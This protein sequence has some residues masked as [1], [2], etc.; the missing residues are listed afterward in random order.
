MAEY[1]WSIAV[2][3][4]NEAE[5][6]GGCLAAIDAAC[7]AHRGHVTVLLNGTT[8]NSLE[9]INR[10]PLTNVDLAVYTF[11][12]ADKAN[13]INEFFY[14]L[15]RTAEMN[16]FVDAYARVS[17]AAFQAIA[18]EFTAH[19]EALIATGVPVTGRSATQ[20]SIATL[21]GGAVNG[22]LYAMRPEFI[23]RIVARKLHLPL[24]LYRGDGLLGSMAAH[25]LDPVGTPWENRR[26]IGVAGAAFAFPRLSIFRWRDIKRQFRR[27]VRQARGVLENEAIKSIIYKSG[28][29][30]LPRDAVD[31]IRDWLASHTLEPGSWRSSL[32]LQLAL[33]ELTL[34]R[35]PEPS[36]L[37]PHAQGLKSRNT[38][39]AGRR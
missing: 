9:V 22:Q 4:V 15:R 30:A 37:A 28:Y 26:I 10:T 18:D 5:S 39:S 32:F 21:K 29:E 6:I 23:D 34:T 1:E 16:F 24:R 12:V 35:K 31:M 27:E 17:E 25:D 13:A 8:D 3:G 7:R 14:T 20:I 11:A 19:P 2:F 38:V 33:R 36:A